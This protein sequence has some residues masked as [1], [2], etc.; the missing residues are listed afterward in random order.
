MVTIFC[1]LLQ[2]GAKDDGQ[3]RAPVS[4]I[5][6]I[7]FCFFLVLLCVSLQHGKHSWDTLWMDVIPFFFFFEWEEGNR[8]GLELFHGHQMEIT[9][10]KERKGKA[11]SAGCFSVFFHQ[12]MKR[13]F[14]KFVLVL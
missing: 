4:T 11:I 7:V 12:T 10:G 2:I 14:S 5:L 3:A 13:F 6:Y 1:L 9:N 8:W